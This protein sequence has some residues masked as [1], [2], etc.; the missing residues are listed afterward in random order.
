MRIATTE[1]PALKERAWAWRVY[2]SYGGVVNVEVSRIVVDEISVTR[3]GTFV[4]YK[5]ASIIREERSTHRRWANVADVADDASIAVS[6]ACSR[7][8]YAMNEIRARKRRFVV[9][10]TSAKLY[11]MIH[12]QLSL[13]APIERMEYEHFAWSRSPVKADVEK[14]KRA[15]KTCQ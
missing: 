13:T 1:H 2:T 4:R 5:I 6:L 8:I 11:K 9:E 14:L 12:D 3:N 15:E 7:A 10:A